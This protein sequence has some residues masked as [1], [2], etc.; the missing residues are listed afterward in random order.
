MKRF[1]WRLQKV[2][3][4]KTKEEQAKRV[5]LFQLAEKLAQTRGKLLMQQRILKDILTDIAEEKPQ[6]GQP[7]RPARR[8][9]QDR[10][11]L[12]RVCEQE[13]VL[14]HSVTNDEQIKI[15]KK[16]VTELESQQKEKIQEVLKARRFKEGLEKLREQAKKQHIQEQEKLEQK[17]L[18]EGATVSFTRRGLQNTPQIS[19]NISSG[20][21]K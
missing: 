16:Q 14:K 19:D 11:C 7:T 8:T 1:T 10:I 3:L 9:G 18:D 2:L 20:E 6:P 12:R 4:I 21:P 17:E 5:E 15:L 13:F